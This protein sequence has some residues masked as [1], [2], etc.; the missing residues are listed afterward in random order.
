MFVKFHLFFC[1]LSTFT[2]CIV[3]S[4]L[5]QCKKIR[6]CIHHT[7]CHDNRRNIDSSYRHQMCRHSFITACNKYSTIKRSCICMNFNHICHHISGRQWIVDSIMSLCFSITDIRTEIT[8]SET[9]CLCNTLSCLFDQIQ[10]MSASR[11]TVT[12]RAFY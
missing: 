1:D 5:L 10:K 12:K 3:L 6:T 9:T 4:N 2:H 7:A 8:S 11:M